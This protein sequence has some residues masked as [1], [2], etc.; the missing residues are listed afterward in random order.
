MLAIWWDRLFSCY[1]ISSGSTNY[2]GGGG[3]NEYCSKTFYVQVTKSSFSAHHKIKWG[4]FFLP[5][6]NHFSAAILQRCVVVQSGPNKCFNKVEKESSWCSLIN[7]KWR[8]NWWRK[9]KI[10][11]CIV[12]YTGNYVCERISFAFSI[13]CVCVCAVVCI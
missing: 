9:K 13:W 8:R 12:K 4:N 11:A 5:R 3:F 10:F 1:V 6:W 7:V 2:D